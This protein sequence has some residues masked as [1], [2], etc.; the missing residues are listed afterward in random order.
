[1]IFLLY[2]FELLYKLGFFL[3]SRY[4]K[5]KGNKDAFPFK[6]ISVGNLSVGGTGKSVVVPFLVRLLGIQEAVII[7]RGY[8]GSVEKS[9]RSVM[10][11]DGQQIFLNKKEAGDEALMYAQELNVPVV[12]GADRYR[13]CRVLESWV[14]S[15][16]KKI[17]YV[18]LDDAYQNYSVKKNCEILLIDARAP[19]DNGHC[20]PVGRLREKDY[21][22]ADV[23]ILT[24]A[25]M[26]SQQE[27]AHIKEKLL[28]DFD[29]NK[30]FMGAH[31][32]GGI[33]FQ[34]KKEFVRTDYVHKKFLV[35]AGVGSFSGVC[36]TA[37]QAG[38]TIGAMREYTDHHQ[39]VSQD[40]DDLVAHMKN[41]NCDGIVTTAKDWV[42]L[43]S[44]INKRSDAQALPFY[45]LRVSF[46]FLSPHEYDKFI[47]I[48]RGHLSI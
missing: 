25:D 7:L 18:I 11:S 21:T 4:K 33:F 9:G 1:M 42:K 10:A 29:D 16:Q 24:H 40:I 26:I 43:E 30:I 3:V 19:F 5:F 37:K 17:N 41:K 39:Y 13:S 48:F 14:Q 23:I 28:A 8:K 47:A 34:N 35:T 31:V 20:L 22:R 15:T 27:R 46:E 2:P 12:V 38:V 32:P 44:L 45:V 6:I 36:N